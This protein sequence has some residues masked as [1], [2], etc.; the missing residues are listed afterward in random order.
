MDNK[1]KCKYCGSEN[2]A[3]HLYAKCIIPILKQNNGIL[4]LLEPEVG[5][6]DYI[7]GTDYYCCWDCGRPIQHNNKPIRIEKELLEYMN[8][9]EIEDNL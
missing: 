4:E 3:Y 1:L 6:D 8:R 5:I 9:T 2:L 7:D